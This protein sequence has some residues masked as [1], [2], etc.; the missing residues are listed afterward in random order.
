MVKK[1]APRNL[2]INL[3]ILVSLISLFC[4]IALGF[5]DFSSTKLL[6]STGYIYSLTLLYN[7]WQKLQ[8]FL[9]LN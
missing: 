4:Y 1:F 7:N 2:I 6:K 3:K 5:Q 9:N 8:L